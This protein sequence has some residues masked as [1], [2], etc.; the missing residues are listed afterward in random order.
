MVK[1]D[2]FSE[3]IRTCEEERSW[4]SHVTRHIPYR[5]IEAK[6]DL[7]HGKKARTYGRNSTVLGKVNLGDTV[8]TLHSEL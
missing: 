1:M 8:S 3:E 5:M 4:W 6:H 2:I 7:G